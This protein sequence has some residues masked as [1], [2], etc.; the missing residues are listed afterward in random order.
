MT[1]QQR[2][3]ILQA[4]ARH[5]RRKHGVF[6]AEGIRCC[7]EGLMRQPAALM[8]AVCGQRFA[9]AAD[10]AP[11]R[12]LAARAG[13]ALDVLPDREFEELAATENPQG[14]LC[15]FRD[16][17]AALAPA[18]LPKPFVLVLDR[19]TEPGNLGT[20]LRTAWAEGLPE[21]W[22]TEG[23]TDPF[24]P[25]AIRAGMGAQFGL[26]LREFAGLAAVEAEM[27]RLGGGALW[28][29]VPRGGVDCFSAAFALAGGALVIGNEA[30][31]VDVRPGQALVTIPMPG[32]AES[33]NAAQAATILLFEAVRRGLFDP[34][35]VAARQEAAH[36]A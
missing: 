22:C 19:V 29:S 11:F 34:A 10:S 26:G 31:G 1:N 8:L 4:H 16:L 20:I 3:L 18:A 23:T 32:A 36:G 13:Q 12:D 2:K 21:V 15:L 33:L 25:K 35:V 24:G 27:Q 9:D 7:A 5:G 14:I 30:A 28:C 17:P 6:I